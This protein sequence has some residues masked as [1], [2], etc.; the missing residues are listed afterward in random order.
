MTIQ[1]YSQHLY[2]FLLAPKDFYPN[3]DG[4]QSLTCKALFLL[5]SEAR[6]DP[7]VIHKLLT[8]AQATGL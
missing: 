3:R 6:A 2:F 7:N 1:K 5:L 4:K 8:A